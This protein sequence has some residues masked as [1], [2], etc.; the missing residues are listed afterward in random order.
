MNSNLE[1][2]E[3]EVLKLTPADRSHL[4]E[5]LITSLDADPE[6]E[7]A[8]ARVADSRQDELESGA[9]E[10]VSGTDAL[11]RLRAKLAR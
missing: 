6:I 9:I 2:L 10:P 5:R 11:S 8:W 7:E 4:L 3:A 1:I